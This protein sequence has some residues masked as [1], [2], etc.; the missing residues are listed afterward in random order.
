MRQPD[1]EIY[2]KDADVD[3]KQIA[4]W[5]AQ[6]I[7]PCSEWQQKGQTFKCK[8]GNIPV[9][10]LPKA[11]GKWNSLYLESEQT[12]WPMMSPAPALHLPHWV[13][14][15]AARRVAGSRKT[16]KKMPTAGCASAPTVKRKSP[17]AQ[18]ENTALLVSVGAGSPANTGHARGSHRGGCFA[19]K[20]A[21]T[22]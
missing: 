16:G 6:A 3:H 21:P 15:C 13:W 14:K 5:L 12:P 9:T 11:V 19:G 1:I 18:P 4:E 7:G 2:L 22:A 10:W 8:A 20:P 17:G